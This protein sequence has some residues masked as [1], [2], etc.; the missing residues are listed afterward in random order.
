MSTL[1][2]IVPMPKGTYD[3]TETYNSLDIV[4][5]SGATFMCCVDGTTGVTPVDGSIWMLLAEDG[6]VVGAETYYSKNDD[7]SN[8]IDDADIIPFYDTSATAKKSSLWSNIKSVLKT[9]FDTLYANVS[10]MHSWNDIYDRP[11]RYSYTSS[12]VTFTLKNTRTYSDGF[13]AG[14]AIIS[15]TEWAN[16]MSANSHTDFIPI[17]GRIATATSLLGLMSITNF[18][19]VGGSLDRTIDFICDIDSGTAS[20][21]LLQGFWVD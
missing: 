19:I 12:V 7:I 2:K 18:A 15:G 20:Q 14:N 11:A 3:A 4:R 1:A 13:V 21:V 8:D 9:Y 5:Y 6:S 16:V 10:H 17:S